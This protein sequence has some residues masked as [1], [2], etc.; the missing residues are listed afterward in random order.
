MQLYKGEGKIPPNRALLFRIC[1]RG[2]EQAREGVVA[3]TLE[4]KKKSFHK[5]RHT[6]KSSDGAELLLNHE[7]PGTMQVLTAPSKGRGVPH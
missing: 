7:T 5:A 6:P 4:E 2:C 1:S 3:T